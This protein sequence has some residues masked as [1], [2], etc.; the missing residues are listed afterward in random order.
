VKSKE[1]EKRREIES[2]KRR[3]DSLSE[4][5]LKDKFVSEE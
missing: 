3:R 4:M 2:K 5:F 1:K